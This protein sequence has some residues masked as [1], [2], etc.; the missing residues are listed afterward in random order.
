MAAEKM[1]LNLSK[2]K[3]KRLKLT[4]DDREEI[5]KSSL[6]VEDNPAVSAQ[7]ASSVSL[8]TTFLE[9]SRNSEVLPIGE[10]F[11]PPRHAGPSPVEDRQTPLRVMSELKGPLRTSTNLPHGATFDLPTLK[12]PEIVRLPPTPASTRP[13]A[14]S[15]FSGPLLV[16]SSHC[17]P[18]LG[19]QTTERDAFFMDAVIW[20]SGKCNSAAWKT[21]A[22]WSIRLHTIDALLR[23]C[24]WHLAASDPDCQHDR[25][26]HG[27]IIVDLQNAEGRR[28][29]DRIVEMV[30]ARVRFS[31]QTRKPIWIFDSLTL[32]PQRTNLK[33]L[34]L[35][36]F[37]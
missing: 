24:G 37:H 17:G 36:S 18:K 13:E 12:D 15:H 35:L 6:G 14:L 19:T 9:N 20:Y 29:K 31:D 8:G 5:S 34:A 32:D 16:P 28:W 26:S 27:I 3:I 33:E 4:Y 23:A 7:T 11:A 22:R 10:P 30:H 25:W 2:K 1:L 21:A